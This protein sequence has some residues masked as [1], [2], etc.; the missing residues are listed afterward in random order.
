MYQYY[1][2]I[3]RNL[4]YRRDFITGVYQF[5]RLNDMRISTINWRDSLIITSLNH[6]IAFDIVVLK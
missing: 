3:A 6:V 5:K 2:D 1:L 4:I